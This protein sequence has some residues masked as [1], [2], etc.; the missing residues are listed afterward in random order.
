MAVDVSPGPS[1]PLGPDV[2]RAAAADIERGDQVA[3]V[4]PEGPDGDHVAGEVTSVRRAHD[5]TAVAV[6]VAN[7]VHF[8]PADHHVVIIR[9]LTSSLEAY[10]AGNPG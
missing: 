7:R 1:S 3:F 2:L 9:G 4:S 8:V 5:G 6:V 10:L